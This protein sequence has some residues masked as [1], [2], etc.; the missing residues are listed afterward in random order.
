METYY[1]EKINDYV[2]KKSELIRP[3]EVKTLE[4]YKLYITFSNGKKGIFDASNLLNDKYYEPLKNKAF[5]N[6]ARIECNTVVWNDNIDI[7]PE[8]L[9]E[10]IY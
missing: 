5:F 1:N 7:S 3:V 8:Y 9:Y 4:D 2:Y 10:T 6:M